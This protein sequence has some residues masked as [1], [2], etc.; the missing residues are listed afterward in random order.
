MPWL[1]APSEEN[2]TVRSEP[3]SKDKQTRER[4]MSHLH[5][6]MKVVAEDPHPI[7]VHGENESSPTKK[8]KVRFQ[9]T[10]QQ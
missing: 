2:I 8:V 3:P 4:N 6:D 9:P 1:I 7:M 10:V 5:A